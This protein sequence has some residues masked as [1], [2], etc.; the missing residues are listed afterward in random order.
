MTPVRARSARRVQRWS[1]TLPRARPKRPAGARPER[2]GP[3][4]ENDA[5]AADEGG[6]EEPRGRQADERQDDLFDE[7]QHGTTPLSLN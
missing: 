4:R 3:A 2:G 1:A 6:Q 5:D 7:R